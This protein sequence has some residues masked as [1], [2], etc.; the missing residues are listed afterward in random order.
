MTWAD[1]VKMTSDEIETDDH[2][3]A[4]HSG[5]HPSSE[6]DDFPRHSE[7]GTTMIE[8]QPFA[9]A[10]GIPPPHLA[11]LWGASPMIGA[12][13]VVMDTHLGHPM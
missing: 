5:V 9:P 13:Q 4:T 10:F 1:S 7:E 12:S 6:H 2:N 8:P 3:H 11:G